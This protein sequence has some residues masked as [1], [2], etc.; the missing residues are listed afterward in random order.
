M[1]A[2]RRAAVPEGVK[3]KAEMKTASSAMSGIPE[4]L[5]QTRAGCAKDNWL[6]RRHGGRGLDIGVTE[7]E[8]LDDL[9]ERLRWDSRRA[10]CR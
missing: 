3:V 10:R 7:N 4:A 5:N 6:K 8:R 2:S 1:V 9:E